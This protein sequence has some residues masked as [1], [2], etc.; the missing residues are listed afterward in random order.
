LDKLAEDAHAR[1]DVDRLELIEEAQGKKQVQGGEALAEPLDLNNRQAE[2]DRLSKYSVENLKRLEEYHRSKGNAAEADLIGDALKKRTSFS[3]PSTGIEPEI[4]RLSELPPAELDRRLAI[5]KANGDTNLTKYLEAAKTMQH[6]RGSSTEGLPPDYTDYDQLPLDEPPSRRPGSQPETPPEA[7]PKAVDPVDPSNPD[8]DYY[9]RNYRPADLEDL[10]KYYKHRGRMQEASVVEE[11]LKRQQANGLDKPWSTPAAEGPQPD[12]LPGAKNRPPGVKVDP[13]DLN[14]R[15]A[16]I[17]KLAQNSDL[18]HMRDLET[19]YR[20]QGDNARAD[21]V[22]EARNARVARALDRPMSPQDIERVS[23]SSKADL[24]WDLKQAQKSPQESAQRI[25]DLQDAIRM[26]EARE[27]AAAANEV[28]DPNINRPKTPRTP[29][30]NPD[31]VTD[32]GSPRP[33]TPPRTPGPD[34]DAV[35]DPGSP[36]PKTPPRTPE[37]NPDAVTDPGSPRPKTPPRTPG[38][39]PDAVTDPGSPRPKTPP[40]GP[41]S[42]PGGTRPGDAPD[43]NTS[44]PGTTK[45]TE[46][47]PGDVTDPGSSRP[48]KQGPSGEELKAE[49]PKFNAARDRM[50]QAEANLK[51]AEASGDQRRAAL[52]RENFEDAKRD[53]NNTDPRRAY[54][55]AVEERDV[56]QAKTAAAEKAAADAKD[57]AAKAARQASAN[58]DSPELQEQAR[59]A[60]AA[61]DKA[62]LDNIEAEQRRFKAGEEERAAAQKLREHMAKEA[63]LK[64]KIDSSIQKDFDAPG[65]EKKGGMRVVGDSDALRDAQRDFKR[66]ENEWY[67]RTD[68]PE[69]PANQLKG[70]NVA[71][72]N[73]R[74]TNRSA[75]LPDAGALTHERF[76]A[77]TSQNWKDNLGGNK[78]LNEG[79]THN[80]TLEQGEAVP[81]GGSQPNN[82]DWAP[83]IPKAYSPEVQVVKKLESIVGKDVMRDAYLK[84]DTET[85]MASIGKKAGAAPADQ[86]AAGREQLARIDEYTRLAQNPKATPGQQ[87]TAMRN[88]RTL[89]NQLER[90]TP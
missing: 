71:G 21:L 49:N 13:I 68:S 9:A 65:N 29:E 25:K 7:P 15:Q 69:V 38:P 56:A 61:A 73:D 74:N 90:G 41:E 84:G 86:I 62:R 50:Q 36:R 76:H 52:A 57:A 78:T 44:R 39:D 30:P 43:P 80:L 63:K 26:K 42:G 2:V 47:G 10:A 24:E 58:P 22:K 23:H 75:G 67:P 53:Y 60:K 34:P 48:G 37:P 31:A 85:L 55:A 88:L 51:A 8:V 1:G 20:N 11:A 81:A 6:Q 28:T 40:G 3:S 54:K 77:N 12:V 14:N 16:E 89:L 82:A 33:K 19:H 59:Q 79:M 46:P 5:A 45:P 70:D 87:A 32:P 83:A 27:A 18:Q 4:Q 17:Q 35:T 72:F 66:V 64:E